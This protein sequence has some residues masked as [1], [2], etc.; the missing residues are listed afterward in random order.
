MNTVILETP[1]TLLRRVTTIAKQAGK[2]PRAM[3]LEMIVEHVNHM[4]KSISVAKAY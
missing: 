1:G 2:R 3:I 4:E